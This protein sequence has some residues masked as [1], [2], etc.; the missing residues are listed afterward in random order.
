VTGVSAALLL[1]WIQTCSLYYGVE[2]EFAYAVARI[3]SGTKTEALRCGSLGRSR[4]YGPMGINR[5]FLGKWPIDDPY[6]NVEIGVKALRG[7]DKRR[8]LKRYNAAFDEGYYRAVMATYRQAKQEGLF[9]AQ[10]QARNAD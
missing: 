7:T 4:Y 5:C 8:V 6:V 9:H 2:P 10:I 1:A 3:E